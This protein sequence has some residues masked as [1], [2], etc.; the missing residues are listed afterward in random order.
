M[1]FF[2]VAYAADGAAQQPQG[3]W[4]MLIIM[5]VIFIAMMYFVTIKPNRKAMKQKE[6]L[7][8]K[9]TVGDEIMLRSGMCGIVK[10]YK[11][12]SDYVVINISNDVPVTFAKD[13]I[14]HILPKGTIGGLK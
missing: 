4:S 2:S 9:I 10:E 8:S 12:D 14:V 13:A 11:P 3:D 6:E 5:V 7:L 1:D